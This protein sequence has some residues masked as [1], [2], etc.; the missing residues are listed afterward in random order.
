MA[1]KTRTAAPH[2]PSKMTAVVKTK[3]AAGPSATEIRSVP[4]PKPGQAEVLIKVL[5]TAVCYYVTTQVA[6]CANAI[7][8]PSIRLAPLPWFFA[9]RNTVAPLCAA[10]P[11]VLSREPSSTTMMQADASAARHRRTMSPIVAASS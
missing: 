7:C 4:V 5:A 1:T 2:L 10:I 8:I 3:A 9:W 11:P 6:C